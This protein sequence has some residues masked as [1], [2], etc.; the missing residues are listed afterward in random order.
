MFDYEVSIASFGQH[1]L[2]IPRG[3]IHTHGRIL[4]LKAVAVLLPAIDIRLSKSDLV[5]EPVQILINS[6]VVGGGAVPIAGSQTR[7]EDVNFHSLVLQLMADFHQ[8]LGAMGTSMTRHYAFPP[9]HCQLKACRIVAEQFPDLADHCAGIRNTKEVLSRAKKVF[10]VLP[11]RAHQRR[12]RGQCF[13]D[14]Y[15]RDSSQSICIK[16]AWNMQTDPAAGISLRR[17]QIRQISAIFNP[18]SGQAL[19]GVLWIAHAV[20]RE[21]VTF[22][23]RSRPHQELLQLLSPFFVAPVANPNHVG[24][25]VGVQWIEAANV[26]C[27]VES[28][29]LLHPKT[30]K[31]DSPDSVTECEYSVKFAQRNCLYLGWTGMCPMVSIMK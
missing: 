5:P 14:A 19:A 20:H 13:K 24:L 21:F 1:T 28:P 3:L 22:Q 26:G 10:R 31:V 16:A 2:E 15:G 11:G 12:S 4:N 8:L 9:I 29:D 27:F 17:T 6:A 7:T 30:V 23:G 25:F 18:S